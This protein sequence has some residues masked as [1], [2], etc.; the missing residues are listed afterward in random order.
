MPEELPAL[1]SFDVRGTPAPK[2]SMRAVLRHGKA[3][4]VPSGDETNRK[5][6]AAWNKA[7]REAALEAIGASK[8]V[9]GE[10]KL[11]RVAIDVTITF[12]LVRPRSHFGRRGDLL[13]SAPAFP[14]AK[15]DADKLARAACD[16]LTGIVWDD[17][18][19]VVDLH[20]RKRY[21]AEAGATITVREAGKS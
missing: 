19:R 4:L 15:P 13:S 3:V 20:S 2:G 18:S 12:W 1:I 5:R 9:A 17:D 10:P 8:F 16:S 11:Q 21:G 6:L 14:I 7:V